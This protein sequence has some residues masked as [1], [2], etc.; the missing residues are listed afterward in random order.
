MLVTKVK[1]NNSAL[2]SLRNK[3]LFQF[4]IF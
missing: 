3:S 2:Y 1:K 4:K